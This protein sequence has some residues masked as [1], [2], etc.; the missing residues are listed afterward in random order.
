MASSLG[1]PGFSGNSPFEVLKGALPF[2]SFNL[3]PP[4]YARMDVIVK[5]IAN[6]ELTPEVRSLMQGQPETEGNSRIIQTQSVEPALKSVVT[7]PVNNPNSGP[8]TV[9]VARARL[10][11]LHSAG[12]TPLAGVSPDV[13][14]SINGI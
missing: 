2:E 14:K 10:A 1:L 4:V 5:S 12:N 6:L 11:E 8:P 9:D 3:P 7:P 13:L